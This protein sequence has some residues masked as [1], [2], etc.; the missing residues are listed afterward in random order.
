MP[1]LS[2]EYVVSDCRMVQF[3]KAKKILI[4]FGFQILC[5]HIKNHCLDTFSYQIPTGSK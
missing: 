3:L 4:E 5:I 2:S 1:D